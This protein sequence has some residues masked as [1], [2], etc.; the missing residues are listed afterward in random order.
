[1]PEITEAT[2]NGVTFRI[3]D[4]VRRVGYDDCGGFPEGH[5]GEIERFDHL[6]EEETR[7]FYWKGEGFFNQISCIEHI[8]V[9]ITVARPD[10]LMSRT[11]YAFFCDKEQYY[12]YTDEEFAM[13][14]DVADNFLS[15]THRQEIKECIE[16]W[17]DA[18]PKNKMEQFLHWLKSN[19]PA[20]AISLSQYDSRFA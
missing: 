6:F 12:S 20:S 13:L 16:K 17:I 3:G 10:T 15:R 11:Y 5:E 2:Y 18:C 14:M 8:K 19:P 4:K 7:V 1:M 9:K